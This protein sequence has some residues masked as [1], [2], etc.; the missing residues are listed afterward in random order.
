MSDRPEDRP[1]ERRRTGPLGDD[2]NAEET[3]QVPRQDVDAG[4]TRQAPTGPSGQTGQG[5]SPSPETERIP[6]RSAGEDKETRVIRT[7]G[8]SGGGPGGGPG[9]GP[10]GPARQDATPYPR[11]YFEAADE[12][13][14]RLRDMYG[15]VDWLASFLGFIVALV[16]SAFFSLI[17]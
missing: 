4:T 7:P 11:G 3:R 14:D 10:G 16:A 12:R 17:A 1:E 5:Q 9:S 8:G 6:Q 15:G 13:E 2:G